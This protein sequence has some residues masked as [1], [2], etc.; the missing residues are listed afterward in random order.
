MAQRFFGREIQVQVEG[1]V[2][3][4]VSFRLEGKDYAIREILAAWA[5]YGFGNIPPRRKKWWLRHHRNYHRV[6]TSEGE[7]FEIYYDHG[8][9]LKNPKYKKWY[10]SRQ[11]DTL[12]EEPQGTAS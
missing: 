1:E 4:P 8:V 10:V 7:V 2:R 5:D 6:C 12:R 9:S 3:H 11:L